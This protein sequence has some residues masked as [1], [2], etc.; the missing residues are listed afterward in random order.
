MPIMEIQPLIARIKM[1]MESKNA[2]HLQSAVMEF[3]KEMRLSG[4]A[5]QIVEF[6]TEAVTRVK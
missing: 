3:V 4:T 5:V 2:M 6:L 1:E